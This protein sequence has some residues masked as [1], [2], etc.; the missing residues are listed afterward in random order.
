[1]ALPWKFYIMGI[2]SSI[3]MKTKG[4]SYGRIKTAPQRMPTPH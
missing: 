4:P 2:K 1:M 3:Y